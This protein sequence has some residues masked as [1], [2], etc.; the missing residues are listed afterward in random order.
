MGT[1]ILHS[2]VRAS[3]TGKPLHQK[4]KLLSMAT[5]EGD[6]GSFRL[7]DKLDY[8]AKVLSGLKKK[9]KDASDAGKNSKGTIGRMSPLDAFVIGDFLE[10]FVRKH[11]SPTTVENSGTDA[12]LMTL[13]RAT[14]PAWMGASIQRGF[15]DRTRLEMQP[16]DLK[17]R[18]GPVGSDTAFNKLMDLGVHNTLDNMLRMKIESSIEEYIQATPTTGPFQ[19]QVTEAAAPSYS[20]AVPITMSFRRILARLKQRGKRPNPNSPCYYRN[21]NAILEDIQTIEDNCRLYNDSDSLVIQ[22]AMEVVADVQQNISGIVTSHVREVAAKIKE[23]HAKKQFLAAFAGENDESLEN[24]GALQSVDPFQEPWQGPLFRDWIQLTGEK[25]RGSTFPQWVPQAGDDVLYSRAIHAKFLEGHTDSLAANQCIALDDTIWK[26]IAEG[27]FAGSS[28]DES[29][30]VAATI[31]SVKAEFPANSSEQGTFDTEAPV[32]ALRMQFS[33]AGEEQCTSV[34]YWRPCM[35]PNDISDE[36]DPETLCCKSCSVQISTSFLR[37][38]WGGQ[39]ENSLEQHG[40]ECSLG[41]GFTCKEMEQIEQNLNFLKRRCL[42]H[43]VPDKFDANLSADKIK[44][45]YFPA[46][47]KVGQNALPQFDELLKAAETEAPSRL[48]NKKKASPSEIDTAALSTL[49]AVG[50]LPP[51]LPEVNEGATF[52]KKGSAAT[53]HDSISPCP[54]L[55]LEL[56]LLRIK[57]GYYRH[58]AAVH[59]DLTEAFLNTQLLSWAPTAKRKTDPIAMKKLAKALFSTKYAIATDDTAFNS[60]TQA[61]VAT[62]K[63]SASEVMATIKVRIILDDPKE[64]REIPAEGRKPRGRPPKKPLEPAQVSGTKRKAIATST[65]EETEMVLTAEVPMITLHSLGRQEAVWVQ[66]DKCKKWRRLRG[67]FGNQKLPSRW[68][69]SMNKND[70]EHALCSAPEE[71][72]DDADNEISTDVDAPKDAMSEEESSFVAHAELVRRL[73]AAS[74]VGITEPTHFAV[75]FGLSSLHVNRQR[76]L[77]AVVPETFTEADHHAAFARNQLGNLMK[78]IARDP[79]KS[80]LP[81]EVTLKVFLD[82]KLIEGEK[83]S[84]RDPETPISVDGITFGKRHLKSNNKLTRALLKPAGKSPCLRCQAARKGLFTCRG[85]YR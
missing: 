12:D 53:L 59:N 82:G 14:F 67:L 47:A 71:V 20:T 16:W 69:C 18:N 9:D 13:V 36:M 17:T 62:Q 2:P 51:W 70:P 1:E 79:C 56:V 29:K 40:G 42:L 33:A 25:H 65:P 73:Y 84:M 85:A 63:S 19:E 80:K 76:I 24:T 21:F 48:A 78:A 45:G 49:A 83:F 38:S 54:N 15:E 46:P 75:V 44:N 37:P 26:R 31:L 7:D 77:S 52:K 10:G 30:W 55:C 5:I 34:I 61:I 4:G 41:L 74:L 6:Y 27:A 43:V 64:N 57:N 11:G 68:Y 39:L 81:K 28:S 8:V 60:I 35:F 22:T 32:L 50:F 23:E 66:C 58:L 72:Y 3:V